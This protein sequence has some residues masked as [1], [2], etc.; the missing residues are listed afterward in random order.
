[1]TRE[2]TQIEIEA[3]N[4]AA[5]DEDASDYGLPEEGLI[6]LMFRHYYGPEAMHCEEALDGMA[7]LV[8]IVRAYDGA[9]AE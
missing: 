7:D 5:I 3:I 2:Y 4:A 9:R 8:A 6:M 1:M